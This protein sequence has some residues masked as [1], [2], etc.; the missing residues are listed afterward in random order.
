MRRNASYA[1]IELN[2]SCIKEGENVVGKQS[3]S[4]DQIAGFVDYDL[5]K[6]VYWVGILKNELEWTD[7]LVDDF[8]VQIS[9]IDERQNQKSCK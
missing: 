7:V 4:R 3:F 8:Y 9:E 5:S 6:T 1:Q 2:N